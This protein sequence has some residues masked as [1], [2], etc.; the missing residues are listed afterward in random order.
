MPTT[1]PQYEAAIYNLETGLYNRV[2]SLQDQIE[3][4]TEIL[5]DLKMQMDDLHKTTVRP[6]E[7]FLNSNEAAEFLGI[8][9]ATLYRYVWR[10]QL[11]PYKVGRA[12]RF[13]MDELTNFIKTVQRTGDRRWAA[14]NANA[15]IPRRPKKAS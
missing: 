6:A 12:S 11:K 2:Q 14:V 10:G 13:A 4:L 9:K 8:S 7:K 1:K 3:T 15:S 5:L